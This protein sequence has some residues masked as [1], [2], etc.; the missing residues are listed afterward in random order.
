[1]SFCGLDRRTAEKKL[2]LFQFAA[3]L[4]TQTK[5]SCGEGHAAPIFECQRDLPLPSRYARSPWA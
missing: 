3:C 5:H 4:V 1:M 2:N